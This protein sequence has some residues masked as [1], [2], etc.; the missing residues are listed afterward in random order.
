M[1]RGKTIA[2]FVRL[3]QRERATAGGYSEGCCHPEDLTCHG[4]DEKALVSVIV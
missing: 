3:Y 1:S 2:H 4:A